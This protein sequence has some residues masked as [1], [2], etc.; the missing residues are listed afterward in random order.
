[1]KKAKTPGFNQSS[2]EDLMQFHEK[3]LYDIP[4]VRDAI[5]S[6]DAQ[7]KDRGRVVVRYSGTESLARVMIEAES[8]SE[9]HTLAD[10]IVRAITSH[11]GV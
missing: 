7:L 3:P 1:M 2:I 8:E 6:A 10:A 11:L 5:A 9:M 4:E